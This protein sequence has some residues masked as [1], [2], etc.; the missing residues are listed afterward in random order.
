MF[1]DEFG[2][3]FIDSNHSDDEDRFILV[4]AVPVVC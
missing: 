2:R 1:D 4:I 3:L